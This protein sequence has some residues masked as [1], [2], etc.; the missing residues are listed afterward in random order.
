V[1]NYAISWAR[2][3]RYDGARA[4]Y[5]NRPLDTTDLDQTPSPH[6]A[7][8]TIWSDYDGD[9][10]YGDF[11]FVGGPP[12]TWNSYEPG[13]WNRLKSG[14]I[15]VPS[16]LHND[17]LGTLRRTSSG[18]GIAGPSRV[19]TAFGEK[20]ATPSDRFG[21][22]GS[23]GYQAHAEIPFLHVGARYYDP[24]SGRFFQ[25]DPIGISGGLNVQGYVDN[26]PTAQTD[27]LGLQKG[28]VQ[29]PRPPPHPGP[30]F[31]N[32]P[33]T[34]GPDF[35]GPPEIT[36]DVGHDVWNMMCY[37]GVTGGNPV[38]KP[39]PPPCLPPGCNEIRDPNQRPGPCGPGSGDAALFPLA[40]LWLAH[41]RFN[42]RPDDRMRSKTNPLN[43][44]AFAST[45]G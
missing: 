23:W 27:P 17:H 8:T 9:E 44:R 21:Y 38:P 18:T 42:R 28:G 32:I 5:L 3:Y 30:P 6:P 16:Y 20:L 29:T 34:P 37:M 10:I 26:N 35:T 19:F 25:R 40:W 4:R 41:R 13:L 45:E 39:E 1:V 15:F 24:S 2:E 22:I 33:A 36:G 43:R 11:I 31:G 12:Q 7:L 14:A